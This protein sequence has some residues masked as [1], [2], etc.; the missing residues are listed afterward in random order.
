MASLGSRNRE[1]CVRL[2]WNGAMGKVS[3]HLSRMICWAIN[4]TLES[5]KFARRE[6]SQWGFASETFPGS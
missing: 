2:G 6:G 1:G 3:E 5:A 4:K